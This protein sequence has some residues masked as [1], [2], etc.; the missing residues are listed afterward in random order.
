MTEV[1]R[2]ENLRKVYGSGETE[3]VALADANLTLHEGEV[4]AVL[5]PSGSGKTTMLMCLGCITEPTSG[6]MSIGG[7]EVYGDGGWK[8]R[9]LRRLRREKMGFIF[10]A[11]NLIPFLNILDNVVIAAELVGTPRKESAKKAM[12]LLEYLEVAHRADKFPA[13]LSGGERQR[14]AI[15]RALVHGPSLI[16]AD[17]PTAALDTDR[18][19]KVVT[20]L[21]DLARKRGVGVIVVTHDVRMVEGFDSVYHMK[22]G[23][24]LDSE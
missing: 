20:L 14:V 2:L 23:A 1:V 19:R 7:E 21:K 9:D 22:D 8:R 4:S 3:V 17:E 24:I 11:H 10:Q 5:G 18:G 13:T 15:A 6:T 12:E 16:L